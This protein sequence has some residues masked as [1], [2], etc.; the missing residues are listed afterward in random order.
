L[1]ASPCPCGGG[2][3]T[4]AHLLFKCRLP[5]VVSHRDGQLIEA[6]AQLTGALARCEPVEGSHAVAS[7]TYSALLDG[8]MPRAAMVEDAVALLL[9]VVGDPTVEMPFPA[10]LKLVGPVL[11]TVASMLRAAIAASALAVSAAAQ[12]SRRRCALRGAMQYLAARLLLRGIPPEAN[13]CAPWRVPSARASQVYEV[14]HALD[15]AATREAGVRGVARVLQRTAD[16]AA[17]RA[18]EAEGA[19]LAARVSHDALGSVVLGPESR[20]LPFAV[21]LADDEAQQARCRASEAAGVVAWWHMWATAALA[22]M[23]RARAARARVDRAKAAVAPLTAEAKERAETIKRARAGVAQAQRLLL[24]VQRR[25]RRRLFSS[26]PPPVPGPGAPLASSTARVV[27]LA[28]RLPTLP[29]GPSLRRVVEASAV[30]V[31]RVVAAVVAV[32]PVAVCGEGGPSAPGGAG[33][34]RG[35]GQ[36]LSP[37]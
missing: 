23:V 26:L 13:R 11:V 24:G 5:Q 27:R 36:V 8:E 22:A 32:L 35:A 12:E 31:R 17:A 20:V 4:R 18:G 9:G 25:V 14:R 34:L 29:V 16:A 21:G 30:G 19:A 1:H 3:Q 10:A 6:V 33:I 2:P 28:T 7:A 15:Y 37:R